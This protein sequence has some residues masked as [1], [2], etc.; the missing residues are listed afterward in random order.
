MKFITLTFLFIILASCSSKK[1]VIGLYGKCEKKYLACTQIELKADN[2][3]EYYIFMDVGGKSILKG[4]WIKTAHNSIFLSTFNQPN[5]PKVKY[6]GNLNNE[7]P[8]KIKIQVADFENLLP[9]TSVSINNNNAWKT[10]ND[11]GIVEFPKQKLNSITYIYLG[12]KETI[13]I[14]NSDYNEIYITIKDLY[15]DAVS[16]YLNNKKL[17]LR[18]NALV[19][20]SEKH[21]S[22]FSLK[23]TRIKNKK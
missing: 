12:Q 1:S 8:N 21:W 6:S 4:K 19:F 7:Y 18:N 20:N 10:A 5:N 3:F 13:E 14:E 15:I 16:Q 9:G 23:K 11:N 17:L 2:T 22:M